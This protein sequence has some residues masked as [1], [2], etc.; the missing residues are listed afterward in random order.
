MQRKAFS[1]SVTNTIDDLNTYSASMVV[2]ITIITRPLNELCDQVERISDAIV[3]A[4]EYSYHFNIKIMGLPEMKD[5][6]FAQDTSALFPKF[7]F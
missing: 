1:F 2:E 5:G 3:Q 6:E 7:I 4:E